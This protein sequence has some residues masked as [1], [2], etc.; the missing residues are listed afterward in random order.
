VSRLKIGSWW[1]AALVAVACF[2]G[3]GACIVRPTETHSVSVLHD[4]TRRLELADGLR[5]VLELAPDFGVAATALVVGAGSADD[6]LGKAGLAHLTKHLVSDARHGDG[7]LAD[8]EVDGTS[9]SRTNWDNTTFWTIDSA[10]SLEDSLTLL[11]GVLKDPLASIDDRLFHQEF[12]SAA[13]E[14]R[15]TAETGTP[16]EAWGWL[17]ADAF[18]EN[19]PYAHSVD[20]TA[21]SL[22]RLTP[23][24]V[25]T[26]AAAHYLPATSTLL[27][28]APLAL[29]QQQALIER[30]MGAPAHAAPAAPVSGKTPPPA[31]Q[32]SRPHSFS[33]HESEVAGPV[34]WIGWTLPSVFSAHGELAN[35][36][37]GAIQNSTRDLPN[38]DPDVGEM[39][40]F[41]DN[42]VA[43]SLLAVEVTLKNGIHPERTAELVADGALS[44]LGNFE[45][46]K[47]FASTDYIYREENIGTR[48][49]DDAWSETATGVPGFLRALG[50]RM[51]AP[52]RD[53]AVAYFDSFLGKQRSHVV[54][55]RPT[56]GTPRPPTAGL[57]A[58]ATSASVP[59]AFRPIPRRRSD[60]HA[61]DHPLLAGLQTHDLEN[62]LRVIL[63]PRPGAGFHT[64]LLGFGGGRAEATPR[65]VEVAAAWARYWREGSP[66][67]WGVDYQRRTEP[68]TT[69]EVLRATGT[70]VRATLS[71]LQRMMDFSVFWPPKR[72]TQLVDVFE[73]EERAPTVAFDH[74]LDAAI[75]GDHPLGTPAT[76]KQIQKI[77]A[78]EVARWNDRVRRPR[79]AALVIVG[80]FDPQEALAAAEEQ[81]GSW[82]SQAPAAP[83]LPDPPALESSQVREGDR[84]LV[85]DRP[86]AQQA[87]LRFECV[88]PAS[89]PDNLPARNIFGVVFRRAVLANLHEQMGATFGVGSSIRVVRGGTTVLD[90][91][92][93]IDYSHL[94]EA[95]GRLRALLD[96]RDRALSDPAAFEHARD[97]VAARSNLATATTYQMAS[98]LVW[99]WS[100]AWPLDS[101]NRSSDGARATQLEEVDA[102]RDH[103]RRNWVVGLLG[104]VRQ[105]GAVG[106]VAGP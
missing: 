76:A 61:A 69:Q 77:T 94:A 44:G 65:G 41:L 63:L 43:A 85:R 67:V 72:Y 13:N 2:P 29:D 51:L 42:G 26:F 71:H 31:A 58:A 66:R 34:L 49:L 83:G 75:Y 56:S 105:I 12:A 37:V 101:M 33:V 1:R 19:S 48:I 22:G 14:R 88:L 70:D 59:L 104:D 73:R 97:V 20:G 23:E 35:L 89:T 82:G 47:R 21:D 98:E 86:G 8:G 93:D 52:T 50:D 95:I 9:F 54:L 68:D 62:G 24:D 40:V 3:L 18:P 46:L 27:V 99:R 7:A 84:L 15:S 103:C 16:G 79:N 5:V 53:E 100:L 91:R 4:Q 90:V 80:D 102:L 81:L 17:L 10:A 45:D 39:H 36:L 96:G 78:A 60:T 11:A 57:A 106:V 92:A 64:V 55:I 32:P 38:L 6:P 74:A 28:T 30:L 25:R 87:T